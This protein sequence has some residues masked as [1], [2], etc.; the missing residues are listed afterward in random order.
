MNQDLTQK[1]LGFT[2]DQNIEVEKAYRDASLAAH[3]DHL[4]SILKQPSAQ[5]SQNVQTAFEYISSH[6]VIKNG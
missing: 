5:L 1:F 4:P 3:L 6:P 2:K